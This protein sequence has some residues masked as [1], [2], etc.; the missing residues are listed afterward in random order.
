[1]K[2]N[3]TA[4]YGCGRCVAPEDW[5]TKGIPRPY[6]LYY[7]I[8]GSA[9]YS[10]G[11]ERTRLLPGCFYLFPSSMPFNV[12]QDCNDRLN[13]LYYDFMMNPSVT[14]AE[15][16]C[17][18]V[19]DHSLLPSLLNLMEKSVVT[20]RQTRQ[21]ELL[22]T[23]CSSLEA[24]LNLFLKIVEPKKLF[25]KDVSLAVEY[26]EQ[27]YAED[28]SVKQIAGMLYLDEGY[29]IKKFKSEMGVTPYAF[30]K[31]LRLSVARELRSGGESLKDASLKAGFKYSSSYCRA[32]SR[33]KRKKA[34]KKNI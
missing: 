19:V 1:M 34:P 25:S 32:V 10:L 3:V 23:V 7:V 13:H 12:V 17:C 14:S 22:N 2:V 11:G 29:F 18:S 9:Y 27:N 4:I 16:L 33:E 5:R 20:Y 30:I 8:G 26:I 24:F 6:R 28:I 21:A 15:P 31:N